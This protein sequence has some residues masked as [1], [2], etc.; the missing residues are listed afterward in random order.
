MLR[1]FLTGIRVAKNLIFKLKEIHDYVDRRYMMH[2]DDYLFCSSIDK[3][4][5]EIIILVKISLFLLQRDYLSRS[6][7]S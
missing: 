1:V 7:L 4:V 5:K 2:V 6:Y 3:I